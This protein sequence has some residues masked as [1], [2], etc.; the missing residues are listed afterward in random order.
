[1][2]RQDEVAGL[3]TG[4]VPISDLIEG[5]LAEATR[6]AERMPAIGKG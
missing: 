1:M 4:V 3:I 5:P 6:L 2:A